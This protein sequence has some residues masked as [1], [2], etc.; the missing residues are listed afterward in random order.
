[1]LPRHRPHVH[2]SQESAPYPLPRHHNCKHSL[3]PPLLGTL[4][5]YSHAHALIRRLVGM[6]SE[7]DTTKHRTLFGPIFGVANTVELPLDKALAQIK[8]DPDARLLK[9][10][11]SAYISALPMAHTIIFIFQFMLCSVK[12]RQSQNDTHTHTHALTHKIKI[13]K[14]SHRPYARPEAFRTLPNTICSRAVC[15][16]P[17]N[18]WRKSGPQWAPST[19]AED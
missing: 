17:T 1:M 7:K 6:F 19:P 14:H 11:E 18:S 10:P 3:V 15:T 13:N 8:V 12:W 16:W 2:D 4:P 9:H 5:H